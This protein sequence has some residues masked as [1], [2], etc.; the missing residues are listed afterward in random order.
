MT[1][2]T[3][4]ELIARLDAVLAGAVER[5]EQSRFYRKVTAGEQVRPLYVAYLR[6]AYHY[7]RLTSSF[8]PLAAR[9]MDRELLGLRQWILHHS[10]DEMGHELMAL[11]DLEILGHPRDGTRASQ[12]LP[13]T[14][15][16]VHFFH[17]QVTERPP[18][19][20]MGVL[21][22]LEGM[23]AK[24][25]PVV[26]AKVV[27]AL[28][29]GE[30]RAITFFREHG[31]LDSAHTAEQRDLLAKFCKSAED[32]QTIAETIALASHIKCF[33]LDSLVDSLKD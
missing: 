13:G 22:F 31:T 30:K 14:W 12:P 23:A 10:A 20:A 9:R 17:Y 32:E 28:G 5:L 4:N 16:W 25:A 3:G 18:F 6:E 26:A 2:D 21:Y 1:T 33:M 11:K 8:T 19:A 24:L 7:V 15:A 27:A 29:D